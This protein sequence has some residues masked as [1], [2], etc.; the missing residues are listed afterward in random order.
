MGG[1]GGVKGV[2]RFCKIGFPPDLA[3]LLPVFVGPVPFLTLIP[4]EVASD[5]AEIEGAREPFRAR[6]RPFSFF[7]VD[8]C[9]FFFRPLP[10]PTAFVTVLSMS[11]SDKE[12]NEDPLSPLTSF[13]AATS[14][15]FLFPLLSSFDW[16]IAFGIEAADDNDDE[17]DTEDRE[18][19]ILFLFL[20]TPPS[21]SSEL[22]GSELGVAVL[23][24]LLSRRIR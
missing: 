9:T 18:P 15:C 4:V 2:D 19:D 7:F 1:G 17:S 16:T 24:S 22:E 20:C 10:L 11:T 21:S 3:A 23:R 8:S 6:P 12:L 14:D 13:A 5:T